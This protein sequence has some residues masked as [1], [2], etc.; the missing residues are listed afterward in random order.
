MITAFLCWI[1]FELPHYLGLS[2][3]LVHPRIRVSCMLLRWGFGVQ[4]WSRLFSTTVVPLRCKRAFCLFLFFPFW[5]FLIKK[6]LCSL[7]YSLE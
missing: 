7:D 5:P 3:P 6:I 4:E 2:L 1:T